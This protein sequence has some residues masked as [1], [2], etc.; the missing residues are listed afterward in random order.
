MVL[1]SMHG[2][3]LLINTINP[4]TNLPFN[5]QEA[6]AAVD[7]NTS[8]LPTTYILNQFVIVTY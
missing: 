4:T 5:F 1:L 7:F 3:W 8:Y 2:G 6:L